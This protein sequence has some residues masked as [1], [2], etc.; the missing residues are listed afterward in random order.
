MIKTEYYKNYIVIDYKSYL[1]LKEDLGLSKLMKKD[2]EESIINS[3]MILFFIFLENE[4]SLNKE[5][6]KEKIKEGISKQKNSYYVLNFADYPED[7]DKIS[8]EKFKEFLKD[9][10]EYHNVLV[11]LPYGE[12]GENIVKENKQCLFLF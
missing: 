6:I 12:K 5:K 3:W 4:I 2:I 8:S 11:L 10:K 1:S 9:I 7:F